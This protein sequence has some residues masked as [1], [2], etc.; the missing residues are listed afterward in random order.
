MMSET[1]NGFMR[2][3]NEQSEDHNSTSTS[4]GLENS[5]DEKAEQ[6]NPTQT[7]TRTAVCASPE[8]AQIAAKAESLKN[9]TVSCFK[10]TK[11]SVFEKLGKVERTVDTDMENR[12][13]TLND[14]HNRYRNVY[15]AAKT[16][17]NNYI[18]TNNAQRSLAETF[19]QLSI[20]ELDLK[21]TLTDHSEMLR[22]NC[23]QGDAFVKSL[24]YFV[25]SLET[26]CMKTIKDTLQTVQVYEHSRLEYDAHRH[27]LNLLQ[28][29]AD[30][31]R[32][33]VEDLQAK[34]ETL[35]QKYESLKEDVRVKLALLDENRLKVLRTQLVQFE[36]GLQQSMKSMSQN[37]PTTHEDDG[38]SNFVRG[39]ANPVTSSFL[40][41]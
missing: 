4:I 5:T 7:E 8:M 22:L 10:T 2:G 28:Q 21:E 15:N 32:K 23:N 40:E 35:K 3:E 37:S 34:C 12:I 30:G 39:V 13:Q 11:Q 9:W 16:F 29:N 24:S 41:H 36:K 14:L 33:P 25:S 19:Y 38:D 17:M 1:G 27:E 20:R 31:A 6:Q 26:L 18:A